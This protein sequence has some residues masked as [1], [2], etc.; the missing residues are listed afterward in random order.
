MALTVKM[1]FLALREWLENQAKTVPALLQLHSLVAKVHALLV[2]RDLLTAQEMLAMHV[3]AQQEQ[4]VHKDLP[5]LLEQLVQQDHRDLPELVAVEEVLS[6]LAKE[7][8]LLV[9]VKQM[10][11]S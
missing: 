8:L 6:A 9:D 10:E 5:D 3:T 7:K 1:G 11:E 2:E 4:L